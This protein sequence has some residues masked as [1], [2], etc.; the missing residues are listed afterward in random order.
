MIESSQTTL[1][2]SRSRL[3]WRRTYLQV[4]LWSFG[5]FQSILGRLTGRRYRKKWHGPAWGRS[6]PY[7][8]GRGPLLTLDREGHVMEIRR[9][10]VSDLVALFGRREEDAVEKA[11]AGLRPGDVVVD[12]GANVG[13]YTVGAAARVGP[14]GRVLAF[15]PAPLTSAMLRRNVEL[16]RLPQVSLFAVALGEEEGSASLEQAVDDCS[17]ASLRSEWISHQYPREKVATTAVKV[18]VRTLDHVLEENGIAR[19]TL[20]KVDVESFE[21]PV[22]RG[23]RRCLQEHRVDKVVCE[24]HDGSSEVGDLLRSWGYIVQQHGGCVVA[25]APS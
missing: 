9:E 23:A 12:A 1:P 11:V 4:A 8:I 19:V 14:N 22:I 16:N 10:H 7:L 6:M 17:V 20:M 15:E 18:P 3:A 21:G 5:V 2:V 13:Q 25:R 24:I